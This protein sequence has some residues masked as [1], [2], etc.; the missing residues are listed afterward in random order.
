MEDEAK[1][2]SHFDSWKAQVVEAH[3]NGQAVGLSEWQDPKSPVRSAVFTIGATEPPELG[4]LR[5]AAIFDASLRAQIGATEDADLLSAFTEFY[6]DRLEAAMQEALRL[7]RTN[8]IAQLT[9]MLGMA[10][11]FYERAAILKIVDKLE[12]L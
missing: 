11:D 9:Q 12:A 2:V 7:Y 4:R 3:R 5:Q 1:I 10:S 8:V 6:R